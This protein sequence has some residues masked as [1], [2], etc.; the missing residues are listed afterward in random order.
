MSKE[1]LNKLFV[2]ITNFFNEN[3]GNRI[4]RA[5]VIGFTTEMD[6]MLNREGDGDKCPKSYTQEQS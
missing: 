5:L 4:T 3:M 2:L 6:I 1:K